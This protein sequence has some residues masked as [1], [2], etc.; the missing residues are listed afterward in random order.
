MMG[1]KRVG[2]YLRL[3]KEDADKL[4]DSDYSE[5]INNQ[6]RM[7]REK[8]NQEGWQIVN[9]YID[10]DY[11][12]ADEARPEFNRLIN[13]CKNGLIDIVLCKSQSRFS[14]NME[15]I[16]K[17][18]H[19]KF[20]EWNIRFVSLVDNAD[21]E[22]QSNKKS[23]QINGLINEWYL[24]DT[25][26][27]IR[28]TLKNK[29]EA[30][31]YTGA[32]A[33]YG[34]QKDKLDKNHLIIDPIAA[35]VVR[36]IFELY[37]DGFG[38][39][40]IAKYLNSEKIDSPYNY[41]R[42]N[43]YNIGSPFINQEF[44][45]I[46]KK[47]SYIYTNIVENLSDKPI[48]NIFIFQKLLDDNQNKKIRDLNETIR[49]YAT[50][51]FSIEKINL[52]EKEKWIQL[53]KNDDIPKNTKYLIIMIDRLKNHSQTQY[54]L[55][56]EVKDNNISKKIYTSEICGNR[57]IKIHTE[58]E[59]KSGWSEKTI[60]EILKNEIYIGN[61]VQGKYKNISYKNQKSIHIPKSEWIVIKNTHDPI[62]EKSIWN[63][64]QKRINN[65][66]V[67][68]KT[69]G[70]INIFNKKIYCKECGK[71]FE[72]N[73]NNNHKYEYFI[74]RDKRTN[75]KNCDNRNSIRYDK[76]EEILLEKINAYIKEYYDDVYCKNKQIT[77]IDKLYE[78]E[79]TQLKQELKKIRVEVD[80]K[81]RYFQEIYEDK[82][83][84]TIT[85]VQ[86]NILNKKYNE[87][88]QKIFQRE[89]I[90]KEQITNI[91]EKFENLKNDKLINEKRVNKLTPT[92]IN[93]L[94]DK[95]IIGR[96]DKEKN[97]RE[98]TIFW[99]F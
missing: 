3:S 67:C 75:W 32:F 87:E 6:E 47:G 31:L 55:E 94:I 4:S 39:N 90:I 38:Y 92:I 73:A 78:K 48:K 54:E 21:T 83:N 5:S 14:R 16:E 76:L 60:S 2:L 46:L 74:C 51:L 89:I 10:E 28:A 63:S 59:K 65:H 61:L 40:K 97:S 57:K 84:K 36:K 56:I 69:T 71:S 27:N 81:E 30:G 23:R 20:I 62:I 42:K 24:E 79:I 17:Y 82:F 37:N 33:P 53:Q 49:I 50:P 44:K 85:E 66:T 22:N 93:E 18:I 25:S 15:Q 58:I 52:E 70:R 29:K 80:Q 86:F 95:I 13:D 96:I 72:K 12:G 77:S 41:K 98:V 91:T 8:V 34:Y 88:I 45:N 26:N 64:V 43:G 1:R 19:N 35:S 7:L 68:D 11:S 99:N 9:I